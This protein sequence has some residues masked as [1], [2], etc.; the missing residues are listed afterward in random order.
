MMHA[1]SLE[2]Y[3]QELPK[4]ARRELEIAAVFYAEPAL[5]M[6]D[7]MVLERLDRHDMNEVR[8]RITALIDMGVLEEC[9]AMA[10]HRTGRSVRLV[11]LK[12]IA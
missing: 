10:C 6:T 1:N 11:R 12:R 2:A 7:R 8:P 5:E 9:G 4:L 3:Q